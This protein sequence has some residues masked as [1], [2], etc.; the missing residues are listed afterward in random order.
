MRVTD[1]SIYIKPLLYCYWL[2]AI[3]IDVASLCSP[4]S[5]MPSAAPNLN[6]VSLNTT[7]WR[8]RLTGEPTINKALCI[9]YW[10]WRRS[11]AA[12]SHALN[13]QAD[14]SRRLLLPRNLHTWLV[15]PRGLEPRRLTSGGQTK[16]KPLV[17][18]FRPIDGGV[19]KKLLCRV[20]APVGLNG[21]FVTLNRC[22]GTYNYTAAT[23]TC[24]NCQSFLVFFP[25]ML[26][27]SF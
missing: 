11:A 18:H 13:G 5:L 25:S 27:R 8:P 19:Q 20:T 7:T 2:I 3:V 14:P 26:Q 17:K 16:E 21:W 9:L 23:L 22:Y 15:S 24:H 4:V 1:P 10:R 6:S 12:N